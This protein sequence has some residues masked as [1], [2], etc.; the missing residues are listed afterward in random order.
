MQSDEQPSIK[1]QNLTKKFGQTTALNNFSVNINQNQIYSVLG[2]NGAG[3]TTLI[4]LLTGIFEPT[5]G[6]AFI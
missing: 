6:N 2:H 5:S 1:I 4:N 3:K